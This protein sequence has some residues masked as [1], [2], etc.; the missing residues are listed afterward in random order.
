V[1]ATQKGLASRA[2]ILRVAA[3]VFADKGYAGTT[4]RDLIE[5]S[6]MT[7]GAFY[8]YFSSKQALARAVV[9]SKQQEWLGRVSQRVL[10]SGDPAGQLAGLAGAM[11]ELHRTDPSFWSISKL[12]K[13]LAQLPGADGDARKPLRQ[14][15]EFVAGLI[16]S[17]QAAGQVKAGVDATGLATVLVGGFDGL[18]GLYDVLGDGPGMPGFEAGVQV[19][20]QL[21]AAFLAP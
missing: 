21:L 3:G 13:E 6:G 7:K 12:T 20:A 18:K 10:A 5:A 16:R 9:E 4:M 17:A 15:V 8:F 2:F 1:P 19:L 14:W 11:L